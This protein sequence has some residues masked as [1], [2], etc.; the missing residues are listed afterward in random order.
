MST[1]GRQIGNWTGMALESSWQPGGKRA[2]C[3]VNTSHSSS[4]TTMPAP[5]GVS[6]RA[7]RPFKFHYYED[8]CWRLPARPARLHQPPRGQPSS[9]LLPRTINE[10]T[11]LSYP[12]H[13]EYTVGARFTRAGLVYTFRLKVPVVLLSDGDVLRFYLQF[14]CNRQLHC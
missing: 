10:S 11:H 14:W 1:S 9:W 12:F 3:I 8:I 7:S 13:R 5:V 6:G 4:G 2:R